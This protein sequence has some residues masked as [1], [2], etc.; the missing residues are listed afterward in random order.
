MIEEETKFAFE[1][2]GATG[3]IVHV[4]DLID[5]VKKFKDYQILAFPGGFSFGDDTGS[6]KGLANKIKN[7]LMEELL[8]FIDHRNLAIGICN[9]FQVMTSLGLLPALDENY[10]AQ[11]VALTHNTSARYECRWVTLLSTSK[12]CVWSKDMD[13]F[14]VPVAHGEGNFYA[15]ED[16]LV[17]LRAQDQIVFKYAMPDGSTA[18]QKFP[19]NPNGSLADIAAICDGT[20]RILGMMPHPERH[21]DFTQHYAWTA[22]N[23]KL[24]R[25]GKQIPQVGPGLQIFKNGVDYFK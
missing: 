24:K 23:D 17:Q 11:Q 13:V 5:G 4:N 2:A 14:E 20:G 6:G 16:T 7:N 22:I 3:D 8:L 19:H 12:K 9:G 18:R 15:P 21:L 25:E 1:C 10:N